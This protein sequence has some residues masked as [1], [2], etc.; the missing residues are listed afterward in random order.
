MP[1]DSLA[2]TG[3][4]VVEMPKP[5]AAPMI[6]ATGIVMMGAGVALSLALSA[7]GALVFIAGLGA[8][9]KQL[10]PGRGHFHEQRSPPDQRPRV[11][12]P[13]TGAVEQL[14]D[15][16]P[17]F[18]M[19]LPVK[20]HPISAGLKGGLIGGLLM[21]IPA[22]SWGLV[23]GHGIWYPVN[24]LAGMLWAGIENM[25]TSELEQ[26]RLPL[27]VA[28]V[29]IHGVM[30]LVL[31]LLY[32]VLLPTLPAIRGGQLAWG[33]MLMPLLWTG[34]SYGLMGVVN[35]RLQ[36]VVDWPFF[37][38]S[39]FVF[40]IAAAFVVIRTEKIAVPPKGSGEP[41]TASLTS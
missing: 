12:A 9:I 18:R 21:P 29:V 2:T 20:L 15:G 22:L 41:D 24:L 8:W 3:P 26:F 7:I 31:G 39:Q 17:G 32:G 1:E 5:T 28:G 14:R 30:S 23:S 36:Q 40:G 10:L 33:G 37:I 13:T 25:T 27:L 16:M 34:L 6:L 4:D 19:R 11:I 35:P 38:A